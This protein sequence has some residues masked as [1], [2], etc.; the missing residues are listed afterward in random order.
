MRRNKKIFKH[1]TTQKT[2]QEIRDEMRIKYG[3][4]PEQVT[5]EMVKGVENKPLK[6]LYLKWRKKKN[7]RF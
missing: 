2:A 1:Y 6:D 4:S 5:Y 7:G 3:I